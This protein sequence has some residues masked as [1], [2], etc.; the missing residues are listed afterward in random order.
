MRHDYE[1]QKRETFETF[2]EL[3]KSGEPMPKLSVVEV[4]LLAEGASAKWGPCEKALQA[5]GF[6]TE[7][8]GDG[9]T[10][11]VATKREV[12]ISADAVWE[13]ERQV[14]EIALPFDFVP[15]GW[16]FGFE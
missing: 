12:A 1:D 10:L 5:K 9:E 8:D 2:A 15:D 16:E 7:R 4:Y 11:I 6:A 13:V 3:A 14:T